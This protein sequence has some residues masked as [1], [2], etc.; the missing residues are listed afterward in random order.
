[1]AGTKR[2]ANSEVKEEAKEEQPWALEVRELEPEEEKLMKELERNQTRAEIAVEIAAHKILQPLYAARRKTLAAQKNFWGIALGQHPE[3][4]QHLL[5][6]EEADAMTYLRDLWVE[7]DPKEHRAFTIEFYFAENPYFSDSVLKKTYSYTD[8]PETT[9]AS[10]TPDANGVTEV[11]VD[12]N[13]ERDVKILETPI[14]WKDPSKAFTKTRPR[15][16][17]E[18]LEKRLNNK[19]HDEPI[20]IDTGSFFHFFEEAED[21]FDIGQTIV[22]EVFADAVGYFTGTHENARNNM[23]DDEEW[24]SDEE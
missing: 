8:P 24:E 22:E 20:T 11:M 18:E 5:D 6:P 12:F 19:E 3:I 15:P 2:A 9:A 7:R 17:M 10:T 1:M 14:A 4:G 16:D 13:W 21:E 23:S